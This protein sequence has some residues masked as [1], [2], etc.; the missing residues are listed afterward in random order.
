MSI[1][2]MLESLELSQEQG[3]LIEERHSAFMNHLPAIA[4]LTDED[5][6]YLYVNQPL[7]DAFNMCSEDLLGKRLRTGCLRLRN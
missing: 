7:S 3:R 5:G 4:S 1:N 2:R 6:R